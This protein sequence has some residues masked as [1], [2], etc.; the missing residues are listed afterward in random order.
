M[1]FSWATVVSNGSGLFLS[2]YPAALLFGVQ[3]MNQLLVSGADVPSKL[4]I[5]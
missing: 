4:H 2:L 3:R 5:L 1:L